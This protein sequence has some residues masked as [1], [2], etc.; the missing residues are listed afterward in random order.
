MLDFQAAR[1]LMAGEVAGQSGNDHPTIAPSSVYPTADGHINIAASSQLQW[2]RMCQAMGRTDWL[3]NPEWRS[4]GR[5]VRERAAVNAAIAEETAKQPSAHWVD[6]LEAA[7]IPCGPIYSIDQAFADPQV[8]HLGMAAPV[9]HPRLG[10]TH[11]VAS[12]LNIS[13]VDKAIRSAAQ[14]TPENTDEILAS[15]GYSQAE[16]AAMRADGAI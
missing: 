4:R 1:W 6:L 11:M 9:D 15:V 8:V 2:E 13:G 16:I 12:P 3:A 10:P 7:G 14:V 5:R